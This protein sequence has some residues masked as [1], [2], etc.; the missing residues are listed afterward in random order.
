MVQSTAPAGLWRARVAAIRELRTA[1]AEQEKNLRFA[2]DRIA[3]MEARLEQIA[4][5]TARP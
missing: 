2:M 4:V 1:N 3:I 5:T